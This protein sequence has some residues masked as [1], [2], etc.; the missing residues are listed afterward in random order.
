VVGSW[1]HRGLL[2]AYKPSEQVFMQPGRIR[3]SEKTSS[4]GL[5]EW[6]RVLA[7][8]GDAEPQQPELGER[9]EEYYAATR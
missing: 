3:V 7:T 2:T 8:G 6:R 1:L 9:I 4:R 5:G